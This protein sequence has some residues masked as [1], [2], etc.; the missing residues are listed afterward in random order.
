MDN[1]I[2]LEIWKQLADRSLSPSHDHWHVDRVLA[3]AQ[4]LQ[5][6]YGGDLE[7]ITAAVLLHDLGRS[8]TQLRNQASADKS[9]EE[10][11]RLLEEVH[12]SPEKTKA[13]LR[14]I[15]EHDAPDLT[16][17]TIE[18]RILKDSDFLAGF[19]AWGIL[20][21]AM[22]AGETRGGV[23]QVFNRL[24]TAMSKRFIHLEFPESRRQAW[25]EVQFAKLFYSQLHQIPDLS[26]YKER[27][28]YIVLEG[29]SGSG[30]D[31]QAELLERR[32]ANAQFDVLRVAEPTDVYKT[33][34]KNWGDPPYDHVIESF[35]LMADRYKLQSDTVLPALK[36]GKVVLSV[37][38]YI[39][40][41]VYQKNSV[42]NEAFLKFAHSFVPMPDIIILYDVSPEV[43][44]QRIQSRMRKK[45]SHEGLDQ[46]KHAR[47]E[48]KRILAS[49]GLNYAI[50]DGERPLGQIS[51]D[52]WQ[53][54][55][56]ILKQH[57][58][59]VVD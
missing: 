21:T 22:W 2:S 5:S 42:Y 9:A 13:V 27:G 59:S 44:A 24:E 30:K 4:Q 55:Y 11:S 41:L 1:L 23:S 29:N 15:R 28:I 33:A 31:T 18:G 14:A 36:A 6:I 17:S 8:E 43:S 48:Y 54:L 51:D 12:F 7:I 20:R 16:P 56:P 37:R 47:D 52:T 19:G 45:G 34:R 38:S 35:L 39:S 40:T 46:L 10:A 25:A 32:L 26:A 53:A 49:S 57:S 50:I 58:P 3:F